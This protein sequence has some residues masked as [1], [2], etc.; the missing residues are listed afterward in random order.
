MDD[1]K[2]ILMQ[3]FVLLPLA[4]I[5]SGASAMVII[6]LVSLFDRSAMDLPTF[7]AIIMILVGFVV[8][9]GMFYLERKIRDF[10]EFGVSAL[11]AISMPARVVF[12]LFS[13][14][15]AF[16]SLFADSVFSDYECL[17]VS[18]GEYITYVFLGCTFEIDK[19]P[20]KTAPSKTPAK[21]KT[22]SS[23]ATSSAKDKERASR[24]DFRARNVCMQLF[25]LL[26]IAAGQF[27][28]SY[29]ALR[30][31]KDL[32]STYMN[33]VWMI[34]IFVGLIVFSMISTRLRGHDPYGEYF[35]EHFVYEKKGS[36]GEYHSDDELEEIIDAAYSNDP[37]A[38]A[39]SVSGYKHKS[40]GWTAY[41]RP[42][43]VL[44]FF[45]SIFLMFTQV[46]SIIIALFISPYKG[47]AFAWYGAV[48]YSH[49]N[50]PFLQK[51]MHFYLG[52]VIYSY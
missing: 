51:I 37:H 7:G 42:M 32:D 10:D 2:N 28:M 35:D 23:N 39:P 47:R 9:S 25:A 20:S 34:L 21:E 16:I 27:V 14:I 8:L 36:G 45:S 17:C 29:F 1:A 46:I 12:Q 52:F 13:I 5:E 48:D 26:P 18:V 41:V 22:A 3:I 31:I 33:A 15:F 30:I 24:R 43:T 11:F 19:A 49:C 40:G 38:A 50:H 44:C 4:A 6:A